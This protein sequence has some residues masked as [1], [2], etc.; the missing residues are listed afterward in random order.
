[1]RTGVYDTNILKFSH[2]LVTSKREVSKVEWPILGVLN[3]QVIPNSPHKVVMNSVSICML[4]DA[5]DFDGP[6]L[7]CHVPLTV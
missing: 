1:M 2:Q 4:V 3:Q 7:D 5:K 6:H